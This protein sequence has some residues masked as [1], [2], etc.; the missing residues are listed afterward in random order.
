MKVR[1]VQVTP[2]INKTNRNKN[3]QKT[4]TETNKQK[5]E[6]NKKIKSGPRTVI[7]AFI[8]NKPF[9]CEETAAEAANSS[10]PEDCEW[11]L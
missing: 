7:S 3:K 9:G 10:R 2:D 1:A 4:E 8:A 6:T 11:F 5:N